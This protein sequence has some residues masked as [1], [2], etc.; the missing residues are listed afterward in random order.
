MDK[1]MQ[2]DYNDKMSHQPS[3]PKLIYGP[4][5]PIEKIPLIEQEIKQYLARQ[6]EEQRLKTIKKTTNWNINYSDEIRN[7]MIA[8]TQNDFNEEMRGVVADMYRKGR[9][10]PGLKG[11]AKKYSQ[12][13]NNNAEAAGQV[14]LNLETYMQNARRGGTTSKLRDDENERNEDVRSFMI[15]QVSITSILVTDSFQYM[16]SLAD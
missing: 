14:L 12:K 13:I 3:Y 9:N 15:Q 8:E 10:N 11:F 7:I 2:K 5:K 4:P 6:F 1:N 16:N